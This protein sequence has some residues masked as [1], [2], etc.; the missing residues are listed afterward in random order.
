MERIAYYPQ[1]LEPCLEHALRDFKLSYISILPQPKIDLSDESE[2]SQSFAS[3]LKER[4][5]Y[6]NRF[7]DRYKKRNS[8]PA[9]GDFI[10]APVPTTLPGCYNFYEK[11]YGEFFL[12]GGH[13]FGLG[14]RKNNSVHTLY[15]AVAGF[16]CNLEILKS[17]NPC[18]TNLSG[19][20][21]DYLPVIFQLQGPKE[22]SYL[23]NADNYNTA[24][25]ILKAYT[26][27]TAFVHLLI[28]WARDNGIPAIYILPSYMNKYVGRGTDRDVRLFRR[29]DET[30][31]RCGFTIGPNGLY[32]LHLPAV[33]PVTS[34]QV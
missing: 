5:E 12:D 18:S 34:A 14:L 26:W 11:E 29:Y 30:A 32:G 4:S 13:S 15:V 20:F 31:M 3:F 9:A 8:N 22:W 16:Y 33:L 17:Q 21:Q 23:K 24:R 25:S 6:A 1:I 7:M 10:F 27:E 19:T 28:E 2:V